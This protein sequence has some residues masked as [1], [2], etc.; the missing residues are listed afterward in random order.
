[1]V[2]GDVK[3]AL[4]AYRR[5]GFESSLPVLIAAFLNWQKVPATKLFMKLA[6]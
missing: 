2:A 1:M 4:L 3:D 5:F 6:K